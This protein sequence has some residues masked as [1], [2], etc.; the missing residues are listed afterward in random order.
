MFILEGL[1]FRIYN[2]SAICN[3]RDG[4]LVS[5]L[6]FRHPELYISETGN[7]MQL[8]ENNGQ[9]CTIQFMVPLNISL[10]ISVGYTL[11]PPVA[12]TVNMSLLP[13]LTFALYSHKSINNTSAK[14]QTL[15][16]FCCCFEMSI[17]DLSLRDYFCKALCWNCLGKC[18][19]SACFDLTFM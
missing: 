7:C 4:A 12:L 18:L 10:N 5:I 1:G 8:Q 13:P 2:L 14:T 6:E 3:N 9:S 11:S 17:S 15:L 16:L 19:C